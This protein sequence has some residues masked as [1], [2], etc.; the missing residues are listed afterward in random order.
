[1]LLDQLYPK[2]SNIKFTV[3]HIKGILKMNNIPP[4]PAINDNKVEVQENNLQPNEEQKPPQVHLPQE[5]AES[6]ITEPTSAQE[7]LKAIEEKVKALAEEKAKLEQEINQRNSQKEH[8]IP[9]LVLNNRK[10]FAE[11]EAVVGLKHRKPLPPGP[12]QDAAFASAEEQFSV[13]V[14]ADG[15]GSSIVSDIGSQRMVSGIYRLIHTLYRSQFAQLDEEIE[16]NKEI[17]QRW[18]LILTKHAKGILEDLSNEY[19]REIKDFRCTLLVGV[20]GK[21]QT[22]WFKVGDGAIIKETLE[23]NQNN[24]PEYQLSTLGE[25]GKGEHANETVFI[26]ESLSPEDVH[27]G[28]FFNKN[29]TALFA[30]SDGAAFK[31]MSNDGHRVASKLSKLAEALRNNDLKR[32]D[33]TKLFY[34][35]PF[36]EGHD[37][38]DCSIALIAR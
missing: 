36:L 17:V 18:A 34:S 24:E 3:N 14:T 32:Y 16:V 20:V 30:M 15:A 7:K 2:I 26:S 35:D 12:G 29:L 11:Y 31:F 25:V 27:Y 6:T 8:E 10:W 19:R 22:F 23:K 4:L 13:I 1:M 28:S 33:L 37:G 5:S 21:I 38:D 9:P